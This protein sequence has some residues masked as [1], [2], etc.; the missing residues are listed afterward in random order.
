MSV[1]LHELD[2]KEIFFRLVR[3]QDE[4]ITVDDSRSRVAGQFGIDE[5]QVREIESEGL[6]KNWPPL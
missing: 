4:G 1:N 5:D 2:K 6:A 3:L